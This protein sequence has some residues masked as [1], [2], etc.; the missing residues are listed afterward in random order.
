MIKK[1]TTRAMNPETK[2][3]KE[4]TAHACGIPCLKLCNIQ[5]VDQAGPYTS[6]LI[7]P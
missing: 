3:F 4:R 6:A 5:T 2:K 1:M 7:I